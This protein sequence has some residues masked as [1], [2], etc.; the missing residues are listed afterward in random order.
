MRATLAIMTE[1]G[2]RPGFG[3]NDLEGWTITIG[4]FVAA[5]LCVLAWRGERALARRDA[6]AARP[7]VWAA[8]A[9]L[10]V[11]LGVNKQLDFQHWL[12]F[13]V[14]DRFAAEPSLWSY[15][16]AIGAVVGACAV[17]ASVVVG[18]VVLRHVGVALRR[19]ALA[20]VGLT[21]LGVFIFARAGSFLPVLSRINGRYRDAMHLLLELGSLVIIGG[22]AAR[23]ITHLRGRERAVRQDAMVFA[24]GLRL[25]DALPVAKPVELQPPARQAA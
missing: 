19:Y 21:Y 1:N 2:W 6:L 10:L 14:R 12:I 13:T 25:T 5:A 11:V 24:G 4:Y 3:D 18:F 16:Y 23:A 8:L 22:G 7:R 20:F 17:V 9:G 15:R